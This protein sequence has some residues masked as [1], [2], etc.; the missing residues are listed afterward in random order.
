MSDL[1]AIASISQA[2]FAV[3]AVLIGLLLVVPKQ[4]D[5]STLLFL[6]ACQKGDECSI[7]WRTVAHVSQRLTIW[8]SVYFTT[9]AERGK[10]LYEQEWA[11]SPPWWGLIRM[12]TSQYLYKALGSPLSDIHHYALTGIIIANACHYLGAIALYLLTKVMFPTKGVR[13][14]RTTAILYVMSPAGMFL[15]SQY[16]EPVVACM[17]FTAMLLRE[18]AK[19]RKTVA[20]S[21]ARALAAGIIAL[22]CRIRSNGILFGVFYLFDL[23]YALI[24]WRILDGLTAI[25]HGLLLAAGFVEIQYRA[26][27]EFCPEREE[28]CARTIPSIYSF[29]QSKYWN[30]GFL[31]YWTPNNIPNFLFGAPTLVMIAASTRTFKDEKRLWPYL[32]VQ[33]IMLVSA[34]F[35]WHVQ[36]ITR[37]STCLPGIYWYVATL[38][39][40]TSPQD[41]TTRAV[42]LNYFTMWLLIQG[43]LFAAFL[44][45]A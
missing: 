44:P 4:Y 31:R 30:V 9:L 39:G 3:K 34:L 41:R 20:A 28:W 21:I 45:P 43:T 5:T 40:S 1:D 19:R 26:W 6:N 42:V 10:A 15:V 17:F 16:G 27:L 23:F 29:V 32:V 33:A 35:V 37:V 22:S 11:F 2:F 25:I 14:A 24:D 38:V 13:F 36:I 12:S 7:L 8:D 18:W